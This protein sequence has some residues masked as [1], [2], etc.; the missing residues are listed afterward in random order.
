MSLSPSDRDV[1]AVKHT[2]RN[3]VASDADCYDDECDD[4]LFCA[5][6]LEP[7]VEESDWGVCQ[8]CGKAL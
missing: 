4:G 7:T 1:S 3:F 5:C 2:P 6:D 8:C